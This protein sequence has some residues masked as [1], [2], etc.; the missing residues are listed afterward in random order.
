MAAPRRAAPHWRDGLQWQEGDIRYTVNSSSELAHDPGSY[1]LNMLNVKTGA[2]ATAVYNSDGTL[3]N[4][5]ANRDW[6]EVGTQRQIPWMQILRES[7]RRAINMY[8]R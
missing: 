2:K 4:V 5:D 1:Y 3:A 8:R 7:W 6:V